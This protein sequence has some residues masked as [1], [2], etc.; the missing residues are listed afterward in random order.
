MHCANPECHQEST[1]LQGGVLRLL[2]MEVAADKRVV[3][4]DWGFPVYSVPT[5]FFWLCGQCSRIIT[6]RRWTTAGVILEPI[7]YTQSNK[8]HPR[9]AKKPVANQE[10][11]NS[12]RGQ[13][14][15]LFA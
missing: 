12:L 7:T 9:N 8:E 5:R 3:G 15:R 11:R 14:G 10:P 2:E 6:I 4:S 13:L 1:S